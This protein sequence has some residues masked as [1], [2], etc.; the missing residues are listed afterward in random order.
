MAGLENFAQN[1]DYIVLLFL[2]V[3][4][5]IF[6]SPIF[7][8]NNIP[9]VAKLGLCCA[10]AYVFYKA[11]PLAE[12]LDYNDDIIFFALLCIKE[13]LFGL[14]LGYVVN[15]FMTL[16]FTAGQMIDMQMGFGMVNVFDV[17]SNLSIPVTGNLLNIMMLLIFF[18]VNGHHR[19]IELLYVTVQR[20]PVGSVVFSA[21][22]G[23]T[24]LELFAKSFLL[25]VYVALPMIGAGLLTQFCLGV[26]IKAMPQMNAFSI[27]LPLEVV[28]GFIVLLM[29]LPVY[30]S[31]AD[32]IFNE[33][34]AGLDNM[35]AALAG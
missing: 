14:V 29:V 15:L 30:V 16:V 11:V 10:L 13:L 27:G 35:F 3:S 18:A 20:V 2:R 21:A 17:Q 9:Q 24:A 32:T 33:M 1:W 4:A 34:F 5:L 26:I 6:S 19:L 12:P 22:L 31:F 8:R 23:T 25:A 28:L 7:G